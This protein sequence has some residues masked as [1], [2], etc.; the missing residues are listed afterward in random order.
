VLVYWELESIA[1]GD[2]SEIIT[3]FGWG[4]P[5][6]A[7]FYD[8]SLTPR[9]SGDTLIREIDPG[10]TAN[11]ELIVWNSG[12]IDFEF[13]VSMS[14]ITVPGWS[15]TIAPIEPGEIYTAYCM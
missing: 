7:D 11:F 12:T 13:N 14:C 4:L 6:F 5:S 10:G 3:Y 15:A 2:I 9:V 1:P 8:I